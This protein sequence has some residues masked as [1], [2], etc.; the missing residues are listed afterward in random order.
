LKRRLSD[1]QLTIT[2]FDD[3]V[4]DPSPPKDTLLATCCVGT[5]LVED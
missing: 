1:D 2:N 3:F 5:V 4:I